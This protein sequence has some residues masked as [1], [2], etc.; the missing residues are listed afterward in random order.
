M[1]LAN[2]VQLSFGGFTY[3][4]RYVFTWPLHHR[5]DVIQGQFLSVSIQGFPSRLVV[6]PRLKNPICSIDI[7]LGNKNRWIYAFPR[8]ILSLDMIIIAKLIKLYPCSWASYLGDG[9]LWIQTMEKEIENH[10]TVSLKI[11][12]GSDHDYCSNPQETCN[13]SFLEKVSFFLI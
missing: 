1:E 5:E 2:P 9:Q 7:Y 11:S 3:L 6:L 13:N 10:S 8:G 12:H 4:L